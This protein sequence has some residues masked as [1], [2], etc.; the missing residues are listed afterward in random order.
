MS[1]LSDAEIRQ[2]FDAIAVLDGDKKSISKKDLR[3]QLQKYNMRDGEIDEI[4]KVCRY[5]L[6]YHVC[7]PFF[8]H[9]LHQGGAV[10]CCSME[11]K[12]NEVYCTS[13][14]IV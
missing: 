2:A 11:H 7:A 5:H 1:S 3:I 12:G 8:S 4:V 13:V 6:F 14:C 9:S 10:K